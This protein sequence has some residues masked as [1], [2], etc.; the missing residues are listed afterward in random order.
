MKNTLSIQS[1]VL[2]FGAAIFFI[3]LVLAFIPAFAHAQEFGD[4][5]G[6]GDSSYGGGFGGYTGGNWGGYGFGDSG[7]CTYGCGTDY[8]YNYPSSYS[9]YTPYSYSSYMPYSYPYSNPGYSYNSSSA[10]SSV[11]AP[12]NTCT[13]PN[14][15]N[16]NSTYSA[17]TTI[18]AP[19]TVT[20]TSPSYSTPSYSYTPPPVVYTPPPTTYAY[21]PPTTYYGATPYV[22]LS[23]VPYT[24]LELGP[25]GTALYWGFLILW[26]LIA[27]YLIVVKRV[28]IKLYRSLNTFLFGEVASEKPIS[29]KSSD[30]A[31]AERQTFVRQVSP[32]LAP[33]IDP[34]ILSQINRARV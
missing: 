27:A 9:S 1:V 12:T 24:G 26:A 10:A 29:Q 17:P 20:V 6:F 19:T 33:S 15:C 13:A 16:D 5:G 7:Y 8:S 31:P 21:S 30:L 23:A 25:V 28:Q 18:N 4:G 34:F 3:A 11:F 32:A 22:S 14:S 2:A